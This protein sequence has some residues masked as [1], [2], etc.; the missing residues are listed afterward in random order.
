MAEFA[1]SRVKSDK[2]KKHVAVLPAEIADS[3]SEQAE[4]FILD[5]TEADAAKK[6]YCVKKSIETN[7]RKSDKASEIKQLVA[8]M[9]SSSVNLWQVEERRRH[10]PGRDR[11]LRQ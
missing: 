8:E 7:Q 10:A 4:V 9:H 6:V 3:V 11:R 2:L 5:K 1:S